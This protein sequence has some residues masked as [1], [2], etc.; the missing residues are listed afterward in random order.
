MFKGIRWR[1]FSYHLSVIA[2]VVM[3]MGAFF[4]WFIDYFYMGNLRSQLFSQLHLASALVQ[5]AEKKNASQEDLDAICKKLS[6][7]IELRL[8]MIAPDGTVLGDSMDTPERM[9]NHLDRP[10]IQEALRDN[11]GTS[12]RH[13]VTTGKDMFYAAMEQ[14]AAEGTESPAAVRVGFIRLAMPLSAIHV[15]LRQLRLFILIALAVS[16]L[17]ALAVGMAL[18]LR[19]TKPLRKISEAARAIAGGNFKPP[20]EVKGGD[21]IAGLARTVK[22][23]GEDLSKKMNQV[24]L[25]KSKLDTVIMSMNIGIILVDQNQRIELIN[26]AAEN[27]FGISRQEAAGATVMTVLRNYPIHENL[28]EVY[29]EGKPRSFELTLYYPRT[30]TLHTS[31]A[32][33]IDSSGIVMGVL[34]LF[35]DITSLR[36]L[37]KMRSEF[38]ANVSHELRTP[39]TAMKGYAET[40]LDQDLEEEQL[41]EFLQI[42]ERKAGEL[43]RLVDSILE[44]SRI[45]GEKD[46]IEKERLDL[47]LPAGEALNSLDDLRQ[48]KE[49]SLYTDFSVEPVWVTGNAD[50][51]RQAVI[52][53]A[54]NSIKYV[55]RGGKLSVKIKV[56][57]DQAIMELSD[58]GPGIP[59]AD[60]PHIFE[61]FYRVDKAR[62][63]RSG[64]SGLGLAIVKHILE[65]HGAFYRIESEEGQG[66]VFHFSLPLHPLHAGNK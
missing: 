58:D 41:R 30:V 40:I 42:I 57:L 7:E 36:T 50:W 64:G 33:V 1:L 49:I 9:E 43:A 14:P 29:A 16:S 19:I 6:H 13:S 55:H 53:I 5:E 28:L 8:T 52:N 17:G 21:E 56:D 54:G 48:Q 66:T 20:L 22:E 61:R 2:V 39:L 31:M 60:L 26:P 23:M 11:L 51:L 12:T 44:L 27:I 45:E 3:G 34:G 18:S 63:R 37:E 32:P 35:H 10:E 47:R 46:V 38:A 59:A 24:L 4:T 15:A 65:A 25:E 62:S